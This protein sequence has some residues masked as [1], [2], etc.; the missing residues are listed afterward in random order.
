MGTSREV[1]FSS[2]NSTFQMWESS[3]NVFLKNHWGLL[4]KNFILCHLF[5]FFSATHH[6]TKSET[7]LSPNGSIQFFPFLK[8]TRR[9]ITEVC[10]FQKNFPYQKREGSSTVLEIS[11]NFVT[12]DVFSQPLTFPKI[13]PLPN[14]RRS[15]HFSKKLGQLPTLVTRKENIENTFLFE[16]QQLK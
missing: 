6:L 14:L 4:T 11:F 7:D 10:F 15:L 16:N 3:P 13:L 5:F 12:E 8:K 2:Q 1:V 9:N